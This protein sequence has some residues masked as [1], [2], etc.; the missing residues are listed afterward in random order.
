ML[1]YPVPP[2]DGERCQ[3]LLSIVFC[4]SRARR[5][6]EWGEGDAELDTAAPTIAV[7]LQVQVI[8]G[9]VHQL[10]HRKQCEAQ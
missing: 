9:A 10:G 4:P 5:T 1:L 6:R 8:C 3:G 7:K 2:G